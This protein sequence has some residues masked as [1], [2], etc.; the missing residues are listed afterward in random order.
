MKCE[1]LE[2]I[3]DF[4]SFIIHPVICSFNK[5]LQCIKYMTEI[6]L[7]D[8]DMVTCNNNKNRYDRHSYDAYSCVMGFN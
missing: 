3:L 1:L 5:Y 2:V 7:E 8:K 4:H 6:M